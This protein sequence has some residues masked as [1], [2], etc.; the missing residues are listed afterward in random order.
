MILPVLKETS[1]K[2]NLTNH[3][4]FYNMGV[5]NKSKLNLRIKLEIRTIPLTSSNTGEKSLC[6]F[7]PDFPPPVT[8]QFEATH[9]A[10][11]D[12]GVRFRVG[13]TP[14]HLG[15][16]CSFQTTLLEIRFFKNKLNSAL[17]LIL[18]F[19]RQL[20]DWLASRQKIMRM[21]VALGAVYLLPMQRGLH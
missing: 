19:S 21:N 8:A 7:N 15:D 17:L 6:G 9:D 14:R 13:H 20:T 3:C 2:T 16:F 12:T 1:F 10:L 5:G 11:P 18:G 4:Y